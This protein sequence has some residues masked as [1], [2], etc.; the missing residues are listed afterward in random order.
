[1]P[2]LISVQCVGQNEAPSFFAGSRR[3]GLTYTKQATFCSTKNKLQD[4]KMNCKGKTK[5]CKTR[6]FFCA[7]VVALMGMWLSHHKSL[8]FLQPWD[9]FTPFSPGR[10]LGCCSN[11]DTAMI[12]WNVC[13]C[14]FGGLAETAIG[15]HKI[16]WFKC[17]RE[18]KDLHK[19][20]CVHK[21]SR[22]PNPQPHKKIVVVFCL[23]RNNCL[24]SPLISGTPADFVS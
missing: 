20:L 14:T 24:W 2:F 15:R 5:T 10:N 22:E 7:P 4:E 8:L 1:M 13:I 19:A 12:S 9:C 11:L 6:N 18:V 21:S 3:T 16:T 23:S 17:L